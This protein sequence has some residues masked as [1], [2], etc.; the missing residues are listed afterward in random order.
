MDTEMPRVKMITK[1]TKMK[2]WTK[3]TREHEVYKESK[4]GMNENGDDNEN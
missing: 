2:K 1:N 3:R 4:I